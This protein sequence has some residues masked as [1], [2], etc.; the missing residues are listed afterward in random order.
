MYSTRKI[1]PVPIAVEILIPCHIFRTQSTPIAQV[2]NLHVH[3]CAFGSDKI[4][5][6]NINF[7]VGL[8]VLYS[9][10]KRDNRYFYTKSITKSVH[11]P[12]IL[13]N[14]PQHTQLPSHVDY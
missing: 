1:N 13:Y 14:I 11:F 5:H 7:H 9:D 10:L 8:D 6:Q 3:A 12:T 2:H 4:S